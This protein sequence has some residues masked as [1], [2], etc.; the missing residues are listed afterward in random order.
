M[1]AVTWG[2]LSQRCQWLS[3]VWQTKLT[4]VHFRTRE[5]VFWHLLQLCLRL[6][7]CPKT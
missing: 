1:S 5:L 2:S 7:H 3:P 4:K 6:Q